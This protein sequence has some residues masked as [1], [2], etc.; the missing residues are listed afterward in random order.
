MCAPE[1]RRVQSDGTFGRLCDLRA[2]GTGAGGLGA[3][4]ELIASRLWRCETRSTKPGEVPAVSRHGRTSPL[5]VDRSVQMPP[6]RRNERAAGGRL[7]PRAFRGAASPPELKGHRPACGNYGVWRRDTRL[8]RRRRRSSRG[9]A[10]RVGQA[11]CKVKLA[12]GGGGGG[13]GDGCKVKVA[14]FEAGLVEAG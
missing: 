14:T 4:W 13:S 1:R 3:L 8:C 10:N 2:L 12:A 6:G 11:A 7:R 9:E 5:P